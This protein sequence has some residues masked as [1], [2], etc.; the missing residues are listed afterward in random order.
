MGPNTRPP[1]ARKADPLRVSG[2]PPAPFHTPPGGDS[3]DLLA[4]AALL[5]SPPRRPIRSE[6]A[7]RVGLQGTPTPTRSAAP[8]SQA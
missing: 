3:E 2:R 6:V 4:P 7:G 5:A 1:R 8:A